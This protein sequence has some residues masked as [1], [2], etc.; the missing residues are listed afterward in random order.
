MGHQKGE[1]DGRS[2]MKYFRRRESPYV[3]ERRIELRLE[4]GEEKV[5]KQPNG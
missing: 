4:K 5:T 2:H 1:V 3:K